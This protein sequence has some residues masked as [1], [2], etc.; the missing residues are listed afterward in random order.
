MQ[1]CFLTIGVQFEIYGSY[2]IKARWTLIALL[3]G[4]A[5]CA[6]TRRAI[7]QGNPSFI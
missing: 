3:A 7:P 2:Q 6:P 4:M 1:V 5:T